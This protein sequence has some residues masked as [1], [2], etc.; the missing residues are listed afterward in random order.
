MHKTP[1][2]IL[3]IQ[4]ASDDTTWGPP[5]RLQEDVI[6][7]WA[8][9]GKSSVKCKIYILLN[10]RNAEIEPKSLPRYNDFWQCIVSTKHGG[11][12]NNSCNI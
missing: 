4:R 10:K 6:H 3:F 9:G 8:N 12:V 7:T 1:S 5:S 2:L 11:V